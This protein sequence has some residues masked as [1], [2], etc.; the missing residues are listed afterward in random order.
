MES[1][2]LHRTYPSRSG[3]EPHRVVAYGADTYSCTCMAGQNRIQCWALAK[4]KGEE[5]YLQIVGQLR[6]APIVTIPDIHVLQEEQW[7]YIKA[8]DAEWRAKYES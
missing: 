7:A 3:G 6:P 5:K 2:P 1:Y 4:L 8:R